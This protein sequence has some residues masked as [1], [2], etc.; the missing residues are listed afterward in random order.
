MQYRE[1][2]ERSTDRLKSAATRLS[3]GTGSD[4]KTAAT[5]VAMMSARLETLAQRPPQPRTSDFNISGPEV[6]FPQPESSPEATLER[7]IDESDLLPIWFL[8]QGVQVQRSVGRVVLTKAHTVDG[9]TFPPGTGWATGFLVSPSLFL[10]NN[11]V[12][13]DAAFASKIKFQFNFQVG[14]DGGELS[15]ESFVPDAASFFHTN[16]SLDYSVIRVRP[17]PPAA[18]STTPVV[19]G[20]RWGVLPLVE[21]PVLR[22]DQL[23]NIIQHPNGRRKEVALQ[24]NKIDKLFQNTV[25]Y[26]TDTEP[27]SSG[28]PVFDN[29][30]MLV[31]LHHAGGDVNPQG[32]FVNN[33][34]IRLDAIVTDLRQAFPGNAVLTELGI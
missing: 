10:T 22:K 1:S 19:P 12:I 11:H 2:I 27:G 16:A 21:A 5:E 6:A 28:S 32:V 24:N 23:V 20:E 13:P 26:T 9:H 3:T 34:G 8:E 25:R 17:N 29:L 15:S 18:G 4:A 33:E 14:P 30:W 7:I 31:A